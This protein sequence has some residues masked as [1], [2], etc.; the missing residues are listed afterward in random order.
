M[1]ERRTQE[2]LSLRDAAAQVGISFNTL[3]RVEGGHLPDLEIFRR[4][5]DWLGLPIASFFAEESTRSTSTPEVIAQHLRADSAL[6]T[7]AAGRIAEIVR[8]LYSALAQPQRTTALH[9][10]AARTFKPAAAQILASM[11]SDMDLALAEETS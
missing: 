7:E 5:V 4:I 3:A 6:S 9:L 1:K 10:R 8:D 11:L 2:R